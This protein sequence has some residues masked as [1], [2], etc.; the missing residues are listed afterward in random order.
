MYTHP[1]RGSKNALWTF[2][3]PAYFPDP[4]LEILAPITTQVLELAMKALT[5]TAAASIGSP[6]PLI[7]L[8]SSS[9]A[10]AGVIGVWFAIVGILFWAGFS[11]D[12][13]GGD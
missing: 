1:T 12:S 2:K 6:L 11:E 5:T 10:C 9:D 3:P 8:S 4:I 13:C 7:L